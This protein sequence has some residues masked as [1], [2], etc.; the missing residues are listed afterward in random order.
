M[1][2]EDDDGSPSKAIDNSNRY[3][4]SLIFSYEED[5]FENTSNK[6]VRNEPNSVKKPQAMK[7]SQSK[8]N[9][10]KNSSMSNLKSK[11]SHRDNRNSSLAKNEN[12]TSV[13]NMNRFRIKS[14][15]KQR[16][17][18]KKNRPHGE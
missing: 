14:K 9:I 15:S 17:V 13:G 11:D 4:V 7:S 12:S 8:V 3:N 18:L 16:S 10:S 6:G 2:R 5:D 1:E